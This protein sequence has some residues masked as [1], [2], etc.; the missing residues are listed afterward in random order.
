MPSTGSDTLPV[1]ALPGWARLNGLDFINCKL[2]LVK[3]R[4]IGLVATE[5]LSLAAGDAG[6]NDD[7]P[8]VKVPRDMALSVETIEN[9]AK[10]DQNFRQLIDAAGKQVHNPPLS[11]HARRT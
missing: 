2:E 7:K 1:E 9:F 11:R 3:D 10:V 5:T 4:G 8:L 6:L